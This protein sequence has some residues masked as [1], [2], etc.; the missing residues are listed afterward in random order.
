MLGSVGPK[1]TDRPCSRLSGDRDRQGVWEPLP[2][3]WGIPAATWKGSNNG[4]KNECQL[5]SQASQWVT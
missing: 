2:A 4:I 1:W 3:V 5:L